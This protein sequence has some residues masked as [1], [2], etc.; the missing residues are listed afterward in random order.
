MIVKM[1][2][3]DLLQSVFYCFCSKL[4]TKFYCT[5]NMLSTFYTFF[6]FFF[7]KKKRKLFNTTSQLWHFTKEMWVIFVEKMWQ[8]A[9]WSNRFQINPIILAALMAKVLRQHPLWMSCGVLTLCIHRSFSL[10]P[11]SCIAIKC[12]IN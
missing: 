12:I 4:N 3:W 8:L 10:L 5:M 6:I 7:C 1:N 2:F 9:V 11:N